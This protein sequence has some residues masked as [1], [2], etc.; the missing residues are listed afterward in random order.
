[1]YRV[2]VYTSWESVSSVSL[3]NHNLPMPYALIVVRLERFMKRER[4]L[5]AREWIEY[6][7]L[8]GTPFHFLNYALYIFFMPFWL[9]V[10]NKGIWMM[11]GQLACVL[12]AQELLELCKLHP[13]AL[14]WRKFQWVSESLFQIRSI[15]LW[16]SA[17]KLNAIC[18]YVV[19]YSK[20]PKLLL[21]WKPFFKSDITYVNNPLLCRQL[22]PLSFFGNV[23]DLTL[24]FI[25]L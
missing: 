23:I 12:G 20:N 17:H 7:I 21:T 16:F 25:L 3:L 14:K 4:A 24:S 13:L 15:Q 9:H 18:N 19:W 5:S 22:L 10:R 8:P 6:R 1:M 11:E 2:T